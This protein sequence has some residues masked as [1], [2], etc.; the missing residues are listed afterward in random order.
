MTTKL[1]PY[2]GEY[3]GKATA[4]ADNSISIIRKEVSALHWSSKIIEQL[5]DP[6]SS[7]MR[8]DLRKLAEQMRET[9]DRLDRA[10]DRVER[11]NLADF[12]TATQ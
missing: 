1:D 8:T 11:V 2:F 3:T 5:K 10:V 6:S 4:D 9:A 7:M 12:W